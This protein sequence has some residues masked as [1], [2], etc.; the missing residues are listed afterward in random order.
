MLRGPASVEKPLV[1]QALDGTNPIS[2]VMDRPSAGE[3]NPG[4]DRGWGC[5]HTLT[6][7][8]VAKVNPLVVYITFAGATVVPVHGV[9][10][11]WKVNSGGGSVITA[12]LGPSVKARNTYVASVNGLTSSATFTASSN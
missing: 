1:V 8:F 10:V 7:P 12:T 3:R 4:K 11:N 6:N 5:E 2:G 9:T